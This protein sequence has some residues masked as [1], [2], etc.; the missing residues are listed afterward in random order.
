LLFV[1]P[2]RSTIAIDG[3]NLTIQQA[4]DTWFSPA[5]RAAVTVMGPQPASVVAQL[6]TRCRASLMCSRFENQPNVVLE[7]MAQGCPVVATRVGGVPE[8]VEHNVNG[9]F[10]E[11]ED[12]EGVAQ[13][14]LNVTR[15]DALAKRIAAA[16]QQWTRD[17]LHPTT[18]AQ[19][20]VQWYRQVMEAFRA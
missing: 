8:I 11:S 5:Q 20:N 4:I 18:I 17:H 3:Q 9:L 13:Q 16:G 7:A 15:D 19:K 12:L 6:R 14:I 2:D 1:G 10:C